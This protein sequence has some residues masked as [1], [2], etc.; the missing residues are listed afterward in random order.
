MFIH[1]ACWHAISPMCFV[2]WTPTAEP[3]RR[4]RFLRL[5]MNPFKKG[6]QTQTT[7]TPITI[8][9]LANAFRFSRPQL[10]ELVWAHAYAN[11]SGAHSAAHN[12]AINIIITFYFRIRVDLRYASEMR[13]GCATVRSVSSCKR[14]LSMA[15][16]QIIWL[17]FEHSGR[18]GCWNSVECWAECESIV[19]QIYIAGML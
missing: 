14:H 12:A 18:N 2:M 19:K 9:S 17:L 11:M 5:T 13:A 6:T 15:R 4:P 1:V 8:V 10:H 3:T 16:I 7:Q